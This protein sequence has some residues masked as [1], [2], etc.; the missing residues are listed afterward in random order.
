MIS[1]TNQ[2]NY[3]VKNKIW[4]ITVIKITAKY[5]F[6]SYSIMLLNYSIRSHC[7]LTAFSCSWQTVFSC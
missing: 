4:C 5:R 1:H 3:T 2:Y 6:V 7:K